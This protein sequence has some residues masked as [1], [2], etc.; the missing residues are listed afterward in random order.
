L[1]GSPAR[2][3]IG[4]VQLSPPSR[5]QKAHFHSAP[6]YKLRKIRFNTRCCTY[7][8]LSHPPL[9]QQP[10]PPRDYRKKPF[11]MRPPPVNIHEHRGVSHG[12]RSLRCRPFPVQIEKVKQSHSV[13]AGCL[14]FFSYGDI[15]SV[16]KAD[17]VT[18][19]SPDSF[20][21]GC[22]V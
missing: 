12:H 11:H 17:Q 3:N 19:F 2:V 6:C 5:A 14:S 10:L 16:C 21:S 4:I 20:I 1:K 9:S 18:G 13:I 7:R 15:P 22:R 8:N